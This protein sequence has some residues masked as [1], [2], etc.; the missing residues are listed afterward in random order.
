MKDW[1]PFAVK[2]EMPYND[3]LPKREDRPHT[4]MICHTNGGG[5]GPGGDLSGWFSRPGNDISSH[6]QIAKSGT[7]YQ[8][9]GLDREAYAEYSGNS[10]AVSVETE[11]DGKPATPWTQAQI[12]ALIRLAKWLGTP[13]RVAADNGLGGGVGWHS[14]YGD[15]N[16]SHHNCPGSVRVGQ[17]HTEIIPGIKK[18]TRHP[19]PSKPKDPRI[20]RLKTPNMHGDDVKQVQ[21]KIGMT[22]KE[23]DG[24]FGPQ[25]EQALKRYQKTHG[26]A[27]NGVVGPRTRAKLGI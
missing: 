3:K 7:I 15:W 27:P 6:F 8:Y 1:C 10:F 2:K 22:G 12:S 26:L 13:A 11:D 5:T 18:A 14:Q 25:T 19:H 9:V 23:V 20:I 21:R 24:I 4:T 17:I 16:Q